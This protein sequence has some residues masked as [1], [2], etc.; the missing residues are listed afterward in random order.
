MD[1]IPEKSEIQVDN[2]ELK[3][4][5]VRHL[6][7]ELNVKNAIPNLKKKP[8]NKWEGRKAYLG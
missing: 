4:P 1:F 2:I 8:Q 5:V 7:K 3:D 6:I